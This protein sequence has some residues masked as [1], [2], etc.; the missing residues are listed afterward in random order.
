MLL[1]VHHGDAV[2]PDVNPM[3]P[4]SDR[5]R[6]AVETLA[7]E[8]AGKG[9]KPDVIWHSGKMRARQTAEAFWRHCNPFATFAATHGLQPT[10]PPSWIVDALA[11]ET[12]D[13]MLVGHFPHMPRL[14]GVL[15]AG[16]PDAAPADFPLH[17]MIVLELKQGVW[18]ERWRLAGPSSLVLGP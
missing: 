2:G 11:G 6:A 17:G 10:D 7:K 1:L 8:A 14:L 15:R 9:A 5:G 12:R 3:R 16:Q 18:V 13:V 4:L